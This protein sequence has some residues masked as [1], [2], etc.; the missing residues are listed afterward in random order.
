[1][2]KVDRSVIHMRRY[3]VMLMVIPALILTISLLV[4]PIGKAVPTDATTNVNAQVM[5][6]GASSNV[7]ADPSTKNDAMKMDNLDNLVFVNFDNQQELKT[8]SQTFS[9]TAGSSSEHKTI[10]LTS[11]QFPVAIHA[12]YVESSLGSGT[13]AISYGESIKFD[14][15][16]V[17]GVAATEISDVSLTNSSNKE[18]FVRGLLS[19]DSDGGIE[20][21]FLLTIYDNFAL[22]LTLDSMGA[23]GVKDRDN[24]FSFTVIA[25][26]TAPKNASVALS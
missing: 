8:V 18:V 21:E 13:T 25:V 22:D 15:Y 23:G 24:G 26:V 14:K 12:I 6:R 16:A 2:L 5:P 11:T 17:N 10:T 19:Q 7:L 4:G 1:M 9:A 3:R 20:D